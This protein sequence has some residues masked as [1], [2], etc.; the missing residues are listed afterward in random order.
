MESFQC[1]P[2]VGFDSEQPSGDAWRS[3]CSLHLYTEPAERNTDLSRQCSAVQER[4]SGWRYWRER[5][6]SGPGRYHL[7]RGRERILT[8]RGDSFGSNIRQGCEVAVF[9]VSA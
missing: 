4:S 2:A 3:E 1:W 5:R 9:E 8:T 6:W 7:G